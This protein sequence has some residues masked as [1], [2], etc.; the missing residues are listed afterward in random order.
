[1]SEGK[2]NAQA[3][4]AYVDGL[5]Q[6]LHHTDTLHRDRATAYAG[7][8]PGTKICLDGGSEA[9]FQQLCARL[10]S[11]DIPHVLII[12][13]DHVEAPHF[14]GGPILTAIGLGP[15]HRDDAPKFLR[16]FKLWT[17]GARNRFPADAGAF[18]KDS[19]REGI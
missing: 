5:L 12:D 8:R 13:R 1:M 18:L 2:A 17:G 11:E 9:A 14:D 16:K 19:S 15:F 10:E 6:G 3:G 7:L 4:H